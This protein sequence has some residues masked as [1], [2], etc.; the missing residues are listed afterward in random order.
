MTRRFCAHP[1]HVATDKGTRFCHS[2]ALVVL[3]AIS[4]WP[5]LGVA[6]KAHTDR[7]KTRRLAL[8]ASANQGGANRAP[9]R[10][11]DSD[12]ASLERVLHELGDLAVDD[13]I[14]LRGA[15]LDKLRQ[16]LK[17]SAERLR[18]A[19]NKGQ[20]AE[21][22]F[23]YSGH[24]DATGLLLGEQTLSYRELRQSLDAMPAEVRI[25]VV[26]ACASG[27]LTRL[28]GGQRL[29]PFVVAR[30]STVK[31]LAILTS[32]S[33]NEASQESDQLGG[34]FFTHYLVS[35]LRGAADADDDGKITLNEAY[36]FAFQ[37]TLARTQQTQAGAQHPSYDMRL[38][39][40]GDLI[41]TR[42]GESEAQLV[43]TAELRG[44]IAV[45]DH[46]GRVQAELHKDSHRG[47][48]IALTPGRYQVFVSQGSKRFVA[49]L[50]LHKE[51]AHSLR[52]EDL[53]PA[54]AELTR[55]RGTYEYLVIPVE[56]S[57]FPQITS[58]GFFGQH[59]VNYVS[60]SLL[61]GRA[62]KLHGFG[63]GLLASW[64]DE[65]MY[66]LQLS[67]GAN[68]VPGYF[69]GLQLSLGSNLLGG[70]GIGIQVSGL[71]NL[72]DA[73]LSWG[74][75]SL[76]S[77][78]LRGDLRGVQL[79]SLFN[80]VGGNMYGLQ[81]A[82]AYNTVVGEVF[83]LQLSSGGNL[84][85]GSVY[86]AQCAV[87]VNLS[88]AT[89]GLQ[90]G[91]VNITSKL[92]GLQLGVVNIS[93]NASGAQIGLVNIAKHHSGAA[94]G[95][96]NI[97]GDGIFHG[98]LSV[99]DSSLL[100]MGIRYGAQ[101]VYTQLSM[102]LSPSQ[103][104]DTLATLLRWQIGL[105]MGFRLRP[106]QPIYI[107]LGAGLHSLH[108]GAWTFDHLDLMPQLRLALG[109]KLL[110]HLGFEAALTFNSLVASGPDISSPSLLPNWQI[111]GSGAQDKIT[112]MLWPGLQLGMQF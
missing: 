56:L 76:G 14:R 26:D 62:A 45:L 63:L 102:G 94:I 104:S 92:Q 35:A 42:F 82:S 49:Q 91:A 24:S 64:V 105:G 66:G 22:L 4:L 61:A 30:K 34:S 108:R 40:S 73:N 67:S 20:R 2:R 25:A 58:N 51:G 37:R 38:S 70:D 75:V 57:L 98:Q 54:P 33:A 93:D 86:G 69:T 16:A 32:S 74:Q 72:A 1:K 103:N 13:V 90:L 23:Y 50:D 85:K 11:A 77:N 95:L 43:L 87:G 6:A 10:Y 78:L 84:A 55:R 89:T 17:T 47:Q 21:F 12:A 15:R 29:P 60:L 110:S 99:D 106:W 79:L 39:G 41:L 107:D 111:V 3:L 53:Q 19:R 44:E 52:P 97:I 18:E 9:L 112:V 36:Q 8:F 48:R 109:Y 100:N 81:L 46:A 101:N 88:P 28:K 83:G 80:G 68:I 7:P 31:G 96:V 71:A 27:Q 5:R 65:E 59:V